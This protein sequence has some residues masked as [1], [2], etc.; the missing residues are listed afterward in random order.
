[1]AARDMFPRHTRRAAKGVGQKGS[2][3]ESRDAPSALQLVRELDHI[4]LLMS[5][6]AGSLFGYGGRLRCLGNA[7]AWVRQRSSPGK[8]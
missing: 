7:R 4:C 6:I 1:M 2:Q 5:P 3:A 8:V